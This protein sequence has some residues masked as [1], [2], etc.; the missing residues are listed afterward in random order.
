M[1]KKQ[2]IEAL[3]DFPDDTPVF[4]EEAFDCFVPV[5]GPLQSINLVQ[6]TDP[7]M[8]NLYFESEYDPEALRTCIKRESYVKG[9]LIS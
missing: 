2:L 7:L 5:Q 6:C 1:T 9:I 3:K 8:P 4:W